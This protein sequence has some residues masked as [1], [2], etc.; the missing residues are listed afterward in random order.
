M[1][2]TALI[3]GQ[4]SEKPPVQAL[5]KVPKG[6][7][8]S[9]G[10]DRTTRISKNESANDAR[11]L[12]EA[13]TERAAIHHFDGG[14]DAALADLLAR[15]GGFPGINWHGL[16]LIDAT[17]SDLWIVQRPDGLL[18]T[19]ATVEPI[20][21]PLSYRQAW[22]ARF[23]SPEPIEDVGVQAAQTAIEKARRPSP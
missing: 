11:D 23:T 16:A 20:S 21:K 5:P 4:I 18:T 14:I 8:G 12:G 3:R 7:Y 2:L 13:Q 6:A 22:P 1:K 19:V 9:F 10:S 17:Q 15:H